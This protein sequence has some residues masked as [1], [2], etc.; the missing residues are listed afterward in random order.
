MNLHPPKPDSR[1]EAG[2]HPRERV[3]CVERTGPTIGAVGFGSLKV[4]VFQ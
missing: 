4:I 1:R 3:P 2:D